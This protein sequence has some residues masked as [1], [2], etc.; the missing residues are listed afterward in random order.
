MKYFYLLIIFFSL[1]SCSFDNK[2]GIWK[3]ENK[4]EI[5][6][7]EDSFKDFKKIT[8]LEDEFNETLR[9]KNNFTFNLSKPIDNLYWHDIFY[10]S[11]N[12]IKNF[13][14]KNLNKLI[15][16]SKKLSRYNFNN[17]KLYEDGNIVLSNNNGD[18]IIFSLEDKK[19]INKFNFY[20]KKYKKFDKKLNIIIEK[21]IIYVADNLGYLY[22]FN[23]K[24][25]TILWAKNYK[26]PF[27][28]N[29]KI[30]KDRI[31]VSN[32]KNNL[33]ILKKKNGDLVKLI[34]T[35]E[36]PIKNQ[37]INNLSMS[38]D[39]LFFLNSFGSL[40]SIDVS[41]TK[42]N[43]FNNFNQSLDLSP[44]N[45][46]FGNKVINNDNE[47]IISSNTKTYILNISDGY[48]KK[49]FNFS[50]IVRPIILDNY[51]FFITKNHFLIAYDTNAQDILYSYKIADLP[52]LNKINFKNEIYKDFMILN[53]EIFIILK[54]SKILKFNIN[55]QF[56]ELSSL[57]SKIISH[58]IILDG[59]IFYLN[60]KNRL[61]VLD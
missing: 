4:V 1:L 33:Y 32:Q 6:K 45:L 40:Y 17:Y 16:Q 22:A 59:S 3:N 37:F 51:I 8:F 29:L 36:T 18:L 26:I 7:D 27:T 46:F 2:T 24:E 9:L 60:S 10:N 50:T 54:D 19:I 13:T 42:I 15:Y 53:N 56:I 5:K 43:W 20:K 39:N 28:S 44:S 25:N 31:L 30:Y 61:V 21:N 58:P 35:E 49:I 34:P 23:Y 12:S 14:Y 11:G 41:K 48:V 38:K 55:G 47:V 52:K 57:P